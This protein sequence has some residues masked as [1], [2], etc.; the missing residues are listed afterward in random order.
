MRPVDE[1]IL[2]TMRDEGNLTPQAVEN[3]DV[4]SRSHASVRLSKLAEYGLV[5]RIAQGLYRL[6][7][8]GRAF[9]NEELDAAELE[10]KTE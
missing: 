1:H 8:E 3:F 4:C 10:P 7:D 6:T 2:E 5:S 9:L